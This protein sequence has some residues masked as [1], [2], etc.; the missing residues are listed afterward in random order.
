MRNERRFLIHHTYD[1]FVRCE[2]NRVI[3]T[4]LERR[5]KSD[6]MTDIIVDDN[7]TITRWLHPS[8]NEFVYAGTIAAPLAWIS[9]TKEVNHEQIQ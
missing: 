1:V 7:D 3:E 4:R 9:E 8:N 2:R 6:V 5:E